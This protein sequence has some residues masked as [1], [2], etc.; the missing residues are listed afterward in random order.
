MHGKMRGTY[1]ILAG[2]HERKRP[3]GSIGVYRRI[4]LKWVLKKCE[5][6]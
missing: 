1:K 5:M 3:F 2:K 6:T 4:I